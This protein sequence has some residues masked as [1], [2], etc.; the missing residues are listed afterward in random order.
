MLWIAAIL[1]FALAVAHSALGERYILV[2]LLRRGDLPKLFGGTEFTA[3]TLRFAWHITSVTW[4]GFATLLWQ[5]DRGALT[6]HA[7][8]QIV[9]ATSLACGVLPLAFTRG[10]HLSWIVFLLVGVLALCWSGG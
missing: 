9:G 5:L 1:V 2:R 6:P 4:F 8:A 3:R 7:T 10:R